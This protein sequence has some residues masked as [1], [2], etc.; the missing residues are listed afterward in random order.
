MFVTLE[1]ESFASRL[2]KLLPS[3]FECLC[4]VSK[5]GR[6]VRLRKED[7]SNL[8]SDQTEGG[9]T[10]DHLLFQTLQL[11]IKITQSCPKWMK[12]PILE[13]TVC[14]ICH[15]IISLISHPHEWVR[16]AACQFL[17]CIF[18]AV[19]PSEVAAAVAAR[20]DEAPGLLIFKMNPEFVLKT[21][22]L[23]LCD[24]LQPGEIQEQL[25]EQVIFY[26][27]Y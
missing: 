1:G 2:P 7:D 19:E 25:V 17:G 18:A 21:L 9:S 3:I 23:D 8:D 16:L 27:L 26:P 15:E 12:E 6:F 11:L 20:K 4:P 14:D 24:L 5:V 10:Q 22:V 13:E